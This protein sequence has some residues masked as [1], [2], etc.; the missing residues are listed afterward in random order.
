MSRL[1]IARLT[2]REPS[3]PLPQPQ[4]VAGTVPWGIRYQAGDPLPPQ[5]PQVPAGRYT[6]QGIS[7][8]ATVAINHGPS[9]FARQ[10][11]EVVGVDVRY[12]NY[13]VD[14]KNILNG[15]ESGLKESHPTR[16]TWHSDVILSGENTG[17]RKS[18]EPHGFVVVS[19]GLAQPP[20][21][22]GTLTSVL[23]G[24]TFTSPVTGS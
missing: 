21:I 15:S 4:P 5:R 17:S 20:T 11:T 22:T 24:A 13:S 3:D 23:N 2:D 16:Y 6:L 18:S 7:G 9:S 14:G 19:P 1:M 8:S 12:D 10:G